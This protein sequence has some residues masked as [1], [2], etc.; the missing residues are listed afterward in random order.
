MN[1]T[2]CILTEGGTHID[3]RAINGAKKYL[4][5]KGNYKVLADGWIDGEDFIGLIVLDELLDSIAFIDCWCVHEF[6]E[7]APSRKT[8]ERLICSYVSQHPDTAECKL[9]FDTI[10]IATNDSND[11]GIVR[12]HTNVLGISNNTESR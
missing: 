2:S 5:M 3:T 12:H 7:D 4:N 11:L 9:R 6:E 10:Q 1:E 8:F